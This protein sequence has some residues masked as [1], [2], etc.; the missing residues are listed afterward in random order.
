MKSR[1]VFDKNGR[2]YGVYVD[3]L[4]VHVD[5][6]GMNRLEINAPNADFELLARRARSLVQRAR[7]VKRE[8]SDALADI[9]NKYKP[10]TTSAAF[11]TANELY[12]KIDTPAGHVGTVY[13]RRARSPVLTVGYT[14]IGVTAPP[15]DRTIYLADYDFDVRLIADKVSKAAESCARIVVHPVRA[16]LAR[17]DYI[18]PVLDEVVA[19]LHSEVGGDWKHSL[20]GG[21]IRISARNCGRVDTEKAVWG[22]AQIS[23]TGDL[24]F[25]VFSAENEIRAYTE[26]FLKQT[27]ESLVQAIGER[28]RLEEIRRILQEEV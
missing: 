15:Y 26:W 24:S 6:V 23:T 4:F 18:T 27:S 21:K 7:E 14:R 5:F 9:N 28:R 11:K 19:H 13:S 3:G 2:I 1:P 10:I 25:D 12:V 20:S 17:Y 8:V 16:W 22:G